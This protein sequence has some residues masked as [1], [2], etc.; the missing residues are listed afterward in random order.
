MSTITRK[1]RI[2]IIGGGPA[3]MM[4]AYCL[5]TT[6][7]VIL[8][9]KEKTLG[10]KFLVAGKGGFNLTNAATE[11]A[12]YAVYTPKNFLQK[13]LQQ[14]D[15]Q[16]CRAWL[17]ELGIPSYVGSSGRIF[18]ERG[19]KPIEVLQAL[20]NALLAQGTQIKCQHRFVGFDESGALQIEHQGK[21]AILPADIYAF[22]LGGASWSKT[23]SDGAWQ[24]AFTTLGIKTVAFAASNCGLNINWPKTVKIH[25][26]KPLKNMHFQL[27]E[28]AQKG[29]ALISHYGLEG[30][31][32]YPLVPAFRA[33]QQ[34]VVE[35]ILDFKPKNTLAQLQEKL[36]TK[37]HWK[38]KD[39]AT[40]FQ[41]HPQQ[42]A[43][44]KAYTS[45][46]EFLDPRQFVRKLKWL[47]IPVK[48]LRPIE[49]AISTVGGI[50]LTELNP[51]G[52]LKQYP[53]IYVAGEMLDWDA[54]TGGY[55]LQA[56]FATAYTAAQ[57]I[58]R[59]LAAE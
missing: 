16:A 19:I 39:Y 54:P 38:T 28:K 21:L 58:L 10:R 42:L 48:G 24:K 4:M 31:A 23:G 12:L 57:S 52:A 44:L 5:S 30:N 8:L 2:V 33:A 25:E 46:L 9:E 17:K 43:I 18:P 22:A 1:K 7:E 26:G 15:S 45:K 55:L 36:A 40:V 53:H 3:G 14:F 13:H 37:S 51:D 11:E 47:A 27:G 29:E 35:L 59:K 49:E 56:C 41:L 32:I 34:E 20:K 50:D 6:H